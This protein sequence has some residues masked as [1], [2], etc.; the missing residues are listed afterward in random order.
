MAVNRDK[1]D[2][3][4]ADIEQSVDMYND[5]FIRFAPEAYRT[6]RFQTTIDVR[7]TLEATE[8]LTDIDVEL[9]RANPS[10]LPTLRLAR[11]AWVMAA[12][13]LLEAAA[14]A[15]YEGNVA[16]PV[17]LG[18]ALQL[19]YQTG[20]LFVGSDIGIEVEGDEF[21][22]RLI[23]PI[24]LVEQA[25]TFDRLMS[26]MAD[27][28]ERGHDP[29]VALDDH[30]ITDPGQRQTLATTIQRIANR[31]ICQ[32][33]HGTMGRFGGEFRLQNGVGSGKT[34]TQYVLSGCVL[35]RVCRADG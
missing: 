19:H 5:W 35:C 23:F 9:L 22:K 20:D 2:R 3:W 16:I 12:R 4:K 17:Y 8:N 28:I 24:R 31:A 29:L 32:V 18:D 10:I 26:D 6:T 7:A 14:N 11:T 34:Q 21:D 30:G 27:A 25:D 33:A 13:P 1:P 15:G